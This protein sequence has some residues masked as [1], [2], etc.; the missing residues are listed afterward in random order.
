MW[1]PDW[2]PKNLPLLPLPWARADPRLL[3]PDQV[4]LHIVMDQIRLHP[5]LSLVQT[6][7]GHLGAE[8]RACSLQRLPGPPQDAG[9][10]HADKSLH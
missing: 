2:H 6:L 1:V 5:F 9:K 10:L 3:Y 4:L 8:E 7:Q